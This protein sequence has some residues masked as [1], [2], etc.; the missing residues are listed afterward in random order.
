MKRALLAATALLFGGLGQA[1]VSAPTEPQGLNDIIAKVGE[2]VITYSQL[3]TMLNSSA[4]VGL[5]TPALG[6]A[7]RNRVRVTLLDKV[8]SANLLYL[9]AKRKDVDQSEEYVRDVRKYSD[10]ILASLYRDKAI[11]GD[12]SIAEEQVQEFFKSTV[13]P[14]TELTEEARLGIE[15]TL[16]KQRFAAK[17]AAM[18]ARLREGI[19]VEIM[20]DRLD[21]VWDTDRDPATVV[22]RIDGEAIPWADVQAPLMTPRNAGSMEQRLESL[23]RIIDN[24]VLAQRGRALGLE[25]DPIF[26]ARVNEYKKTRLINLYRGQLI[27]SMI[28]NDKELAHHFEANRHSIAI[29]EARK[30]QMLVL[31]TEAEAKE[32][33]R[34]IEAGELTSYEAASQ[35]SIDPNAKQTLGEFGWVNQGSGFADLDE[36]TFSLAPDTLGGPVQTPSGWTLVKVLDMRDARYQSLD[37]ADTRAYTRRRYIHQRLNDHVVELRKHVFPVVV[38]EKTLTELFTREAKWIAE[39]EQRAAEDPAR[40]QARMQTL[41]KAFQ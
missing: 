39:L 37:D 28:P 18:R 26:Q 4:I 34:R 19:Q 31:E 22:A 15:A 27:P 3:N 9:D 23:D 12:L 7:E 8:I 25:Q 32:I 10:A 5:S 40:T 33:Q 6:T 13:L 2:E 16:R 21:P 11:V 29:P 20:R 35:F 41:R 1:S 36:L 17:I 14:G 38:Y 30:I 24:R